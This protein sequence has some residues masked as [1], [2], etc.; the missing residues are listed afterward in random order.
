MNQLI[1]YG[2]YTFAH[3]AFPIVIMI[4][5]IFIEAISSIPSFFVFR[6]VNIRF[7]RYKKD[8][9]I[10]FF[11]YFRVYNTVAYKIIFRNVLGRTFCC[12]PIFF[13]FYGMSFLPD[14]KKFIKGFSFGSF[15]F[16]F[17]KCHKEHLLSI[18]YFYYIASVLYFQHFSMNK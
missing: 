1:K 14:I 2:T 4:I 5:I 7:V 8:F 10:F 6:I 18:F 15:L 11:E 9:I 12:F 17:F 16:K 3:F 13:T